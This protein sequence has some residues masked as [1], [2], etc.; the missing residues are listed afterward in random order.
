MITEFWATAPLT[1]PK[2]NL[3]RTIYIL[4]L[5]QDRTIA[6][7]LPINIQSPKYNVVSLFILLGL[8]QIIQIFKKL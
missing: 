2:N 4:P 6:F 8:K 7:M 1:Y 5:E 3:V